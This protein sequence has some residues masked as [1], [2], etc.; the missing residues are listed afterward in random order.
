MMV[1]RRPLSI[2]EEVG[3]W[4]GGAGAAAGRRFGGSRKALKLPTES[5][6]RAPLHHFPFH[7]VIADLIP[8][9]VQNQ[10]GF[11]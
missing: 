7:V 1:I 9:L 6:Q 10:K 8:F 11:S 5:P 4:G 2:R 3:R